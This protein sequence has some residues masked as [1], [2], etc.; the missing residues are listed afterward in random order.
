MQNYFLVFVTFLFILSSCLKESD[1]K[2]SINT[3]MKVKY[4]DRS[5]DFSEDK[6]NFKSFWQKSVETYTMET[7]C[8][9]NCEAFQTMQASMQEFGG[10]LPDIIENSNRNF[11]CDELRSIWGS[12]S[13]TLQEK[14]QIFKTEVK[15]NIFLT[16]DEV[17]LLNLLIDDLMLNTINTDFNKYRNLWNTLET[18][19]SVNNGASALIIESVSSVMT[20]YPDFM[21]E[22]EPSAL[23][24]K[25]VGAA[26]GAF[27]GGMTDIFGPGGDNTPS[28]N[29][30][31]N[32]AWGA[33]GGAISA[34]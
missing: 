30:F 1:E 9:C 29:F 11:E 3:S 7:L 6:M 8:A 28:D 34:L 26:F 10:L 20:N 2:T 17:E 23:V 21:D 13:Y 16:K 14:V 18:Q 22:E 33:V 25:A 32:M 27:W 19:S 15:E 24:N 4:L 12:C 5:F 31:S